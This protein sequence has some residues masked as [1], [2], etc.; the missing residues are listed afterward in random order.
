MTE[1]VRYHAEVALPGLVVGVVAGLMAGGLTLLAGH[2]PGWAAISALSL[3]VPMGLLGAG[4]GVLL[5]RNVFQPGVFAPAGL[6]WLIGFP[7]SRLVQETV[8]STVILGRATLTEDLPAFLA[9]QAIVSLG[10]AIGFVWMHERLAPHWFMHV[11]GRNPVAR[12]VLDRY[13]GHAEALWRVRGRR[14]A[15]RRGEKGAG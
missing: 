8:T 15:L 11:A 4:Y 12:E 1:R 10:F 7:I 5:G 3:A 9:Y 14:R 6:Y 13:I 2:R